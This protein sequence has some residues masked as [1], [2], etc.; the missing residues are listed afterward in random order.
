MS[1]LQ[2][3][4]GVRLKH[5]ANGPDPPPA[6]FLVA[7]ISPRMNRRKHLTGWVKMLL[8]SGS[9]PMR[10]YLIHEFEARKR[11][12]PRYSLRA[13]AR[14][15]QIASSL[16]SRLLRGTVPITSKMFLRIE[17]KIT[18][19]PGLRDQFKK[20]I[21]EG[22]RKRKEKGSQGSSRWGRKGD[23]VADDVISFI[24]P[25]HPS[26]LPEVIR[27][28]RAFQESLESKVKE[29]GEPHETVCELHVSFRSLAKS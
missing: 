18:P 14:D 17:P 5:A 25:C 16:L 9:D 13:Y 2:G 28:I 8:K 29:S 19:P 22:E 26:L 11:I 3:L 20:E 27:E 10:N 15:L 4:V 21:Q 24:L 7:P 1:T 23:G 12:N 6:T